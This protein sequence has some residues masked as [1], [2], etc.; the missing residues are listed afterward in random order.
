MT[1]CSFPDVNMHSN[2]PQ[3]HNKQC[4]QLNYFADETNPEAL[5]E[6]SVFVSCV[7][8]FTQQNYL[9]GETLLHKD[10]LRRSLNPQC[11]QCVS[12]TIWSAARIGGCSRMNYEVQMQQG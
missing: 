11:F 10:P 3:K 1:V 12:V 4:L 9:Q 6:T 8:H 7:Y 5:L 2:A